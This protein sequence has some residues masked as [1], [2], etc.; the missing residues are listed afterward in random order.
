MKTKVELS[1]GSL[2][3]VCEMEGTIKCCS[4][5]IEDT[6]RSDIFTFLPTH[7]LE[8]VNVSVTVRK[9]DKHIEIVE[10]IKSDE[11]IIE[12]IKDLIISIFKRHATVLIPRLVM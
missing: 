11:A 6:L 5:I 12:T 2:K 9:V 7:L 3:L 4:A 1:K 8:K 10:E